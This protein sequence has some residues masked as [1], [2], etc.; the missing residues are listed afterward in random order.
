MSRSLGAELLAKW[1]AEAR[2]RLEDA[3]R[4]FI[5]DMSAVSLWE[6]GKRTPSKEMAE[7]I[8]EVC[9]IPVAS[10]RAK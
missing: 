2:L 9:K 3:A 7:R 1:R 4:L 10:W 5:C 8:H 6:S